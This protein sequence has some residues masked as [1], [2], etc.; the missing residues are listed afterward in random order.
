MVLEFTIVILESFVQYFEIVS[1]LIIIYG[2]L[3]TVFKILLI[4]ILKR[5]E[6]YQ[7]IRKEF[8]D[9]ILFGLELLIIADL[10]ETLRKPSGEDLLLVGAIVIIR[11]FLGHF[12][13]KEAGEYNFD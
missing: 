12:L 6:S 1:A 10:L 5:P 2:G 11:T 9:R 4:E 13:S 8:T 3:R 7:K